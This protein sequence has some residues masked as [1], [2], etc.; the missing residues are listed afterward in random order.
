[1]KCETSPS[2][3]LTCADLYQKECQEIWDVKRTFWGK[4]QMADFA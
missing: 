3:T 4:M 1:M 2:G